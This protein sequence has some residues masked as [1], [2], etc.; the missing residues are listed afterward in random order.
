MFGRWLPN[1]NKKNINYHIEPINLDNFNNIELVG[2]RIRMGNEKSIFIFCAYIPPN[3]ATSFDAYETLLNAINSVEIKSND[4]CILL[5]D[6]NLP[7]INCSFNN[8]NRLVPYNFIPGFTVKLF[9][10]ITSKGRRQLNYIKNDKNHIL[11]LIFLNDELKYDLRECKNPLVKI[12]KPH[13]PIECKIFDVLPKREII[14]RKK[15]ETTMYNFKRTDFVA[16]N[17]Y[18]NDINIC[19]I[20][21]NMDVERAFSC[22]Y[23]IIKFS[24]EKYVPK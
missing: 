15:A 8:E 6:L 20:V 21:S 2:A 18:F 10:E 22:F 12:D 3:R 19:E 24:Y 17:D 23:N 9:D 16:M 1:C 5:G 11:D 14:E 4:V 7:K 13:P